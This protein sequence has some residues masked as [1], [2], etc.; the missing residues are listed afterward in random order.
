MS[1]TGSLKRTERAAAPARF[2][3]RRI[4]M[5]IASALFTI[6]L[7]SFRPFQPTGALAGP[8]SLPAEGGDIVNQVG[9]LSLGLVAIF[10]LF[11]YVEPRKL[12]GLLSPWWLLLILLFMLSVFHAREPDAA[13]RA[14]IFTLMGIVSIAAVIVL[15]RD[16]DAFSTVMACAGSVVV[17]LSFIGLVI[18]PN[19]AMH[20][21]AD[22][23]EP[24]FAGLW[25]GVFSH[26]NIAGPVMACLSFGGL[27]LWRRGWTRSGL[28]LF[29]GA[30]IFMVNTGS[31]TTAGLVPLSILIVMMPTLIGMRLLTPILVA[32]TL[33]VTALATLGIV[34]IE[35]LKEFAN[36]LV[37]GINYTGRTTLWAFAGEHIAERP[38]FGYGFQSFWGSPIVQYKELFFDD[39]WDIRGIVHGHNGYLDIA[40]QMGLPA[41][42]VTA[43]TFL[44]APLRDYMRV[45]LYK[46][47]VYLADFFMMVVLFT[48]L[49]AFLETFFLRRADPV[50]LLLVFGL[51]GLRIVARFPMPTRVRE[52]GQ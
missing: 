52:N 4:A 31:K 50:W 15:P 20:T 33:L 7:V 18:L 34:F 17:G 38:W 16:G 30:M 11:T 27:Y 28:L 5:I 21:F 46:E 25:R 37:P 8:D 10:S 35:P 2:S 48:T 40:I 45:P 26:K 29:A 19:E 1:S 3:E 39:E 43:I 14:A 41:M 9:F 23:V 12:L 42:I 44:V 22:G 51:L 47:N 32:L 36:W 13:M 6:L 49:D 24:E